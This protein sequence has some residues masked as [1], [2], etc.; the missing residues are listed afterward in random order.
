MQS[1]VDRFS[2]VLHLTRITHG[3][4]ATANVWFVVLWTRATQ[5]ESLHDTTRILFAKL[6]EVLAASAV[7][8]LGLFVFA[9]VM[10]DLFDVRRDR[11]LKRGRPIATGQASAE[12]A[13]VVLALA[14]L[15]SVASAWWLGGWSVPMVA[16]VAAGVVLYELLLRH[17]PSI[18]LVTIGLLYAGHMLTPNAELVFLWPVVWAMS[19]ALL[20][21]MMTHSISNRRPALDA[22]AIAIAAGGWLVWVGV[23]AFA[24]TVRSGELWPGVVPAMVLPVQMLLLGG[25]GVV[26]WRKSL[27]TSNRVRRA[28]KIRR[29]GSLWQP[30]YGTVWCLAAGLYREA[31][32]LGGL[33]AIGF[34]SLTFLRE[35]YSLIEQP[36]GYRR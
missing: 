5:Q 16:A 14:L 35:L 28:E 7:M 10:H 23:F 32:V 15:A 26:A 4:A 33:A 34:L 24:G 18:G 12:G 30:L 9:M 19:H 22:G 31:A 27:N 25:F 6:W 2:P 21:G 11:A 13:A 1:L 17:V 3:V 29:Y 20:V 36:V 8:A